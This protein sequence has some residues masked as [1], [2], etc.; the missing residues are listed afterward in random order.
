[1][2]DARAPIGLAQGAGAL[3]A[4]LITSALM[5]GVYTIVGEAAEN[6]WTSARMFVFGGVALLLFVGF[7]VREATHPRPLLPLRVFKSRNVSGTNLA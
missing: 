2:A 7:I 6:G 1:V 5:L 3:G 4:G